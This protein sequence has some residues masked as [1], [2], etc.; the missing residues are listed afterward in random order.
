MT[1]PNAVMVSACIST[2]CHRGSLVTF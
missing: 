1:R 2:V